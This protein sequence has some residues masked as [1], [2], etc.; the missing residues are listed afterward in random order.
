MHEPLST[1][2][3]SAQENNRHYT[4]FPGARARKLSE[5]LPCK[6]PPSV[7]PRENAFVSRFFRPLREPAAG[8]F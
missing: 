1:V 8:F 3:A 2:S 4:R 5:F 6:V 7:F